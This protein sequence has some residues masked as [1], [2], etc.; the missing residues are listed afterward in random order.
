MVTS[1]RR[2][3]IDKFYDDLSKIWDKTRPKYTA[4]IFSK[5]IS[6]LDKNKPY[7]IL[8]FGCGTGL[9]C[10]NLH[11][12]LPNAKI[13]G[14]DISG[15]MIEKAKTNCPNCNFYVGDILSF[16]LPKYDIVVSKDV[17]NHVEDIHKTVTRLDELL[18]DLGKLI[19]ANRERNKGEKNKITDALRQLGYKISA[20]HFSFKPTKKEIDDFTAEL[21]AFIEEH[22][23]FIRKKLEESGEYYIIFADKAN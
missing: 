2:L 10:K 14:I 1:Y 21:P 6:H 20:E 15:Q 22:K 19:I 9:L 23:A 17:F 5:I 13:E 4:E 12:N 7:S 8:D 16:N 18:T 3:E 11:E